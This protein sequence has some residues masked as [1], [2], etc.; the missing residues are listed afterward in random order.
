MPDLFGAP[1]DLDD[2]L[3]AAER[4]RRLYEAADRAPVGSEE[5]ARLYRLAAAAQRLAE[6]HQAARNRRAEREL[7]RREATRARFG[8]AGQPAGA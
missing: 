6:R 5:R 8:R 1:V 4:A 2:D 3:P 7:A